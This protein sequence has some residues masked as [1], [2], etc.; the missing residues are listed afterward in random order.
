MQRPT[1]AIAPRPGRRDSRHDPRGRGTTQHRR[2]LRAR[3]GGRS[4]D[5]ARQRGGHGAVVQQS[6]NAPPPTNS[7]RRKTTYTAVV[8]TGSQRPGG[9]PARPERHPKPACSKRRGGSRCAAR[10]QKPSDTA[11]YGL[12]S[13]M[14]GHFQPSAFSKNKKLMADGASSAP[15][16]DHPG[17]ECEG[18][19]SRADGSSGVQ[20]AEPKTAPRRAP[21]WMWWHSGHG[22]APSLR[23]ALRTP[24]MI[25]QSMPFAFRCRPLLAQA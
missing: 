19:G 14:H 7:L 10:A 21:L 18:G 24:R 8:T 25:R 2:P 11:Q 6:T 4:G 17:R 23:V 12:L 22:D 1:E 5:V 9:Q 15:T 13:L 20:A 3:C 16:E